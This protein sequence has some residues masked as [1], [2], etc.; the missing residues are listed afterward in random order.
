MTRR[1]FHVFASL[2]EARAYRHEHGC[3][4]WI[5]QDDATGEATI[6]PPDMT[7]TAILQ[8]PLARG[9][10]GNLIGNG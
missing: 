8:H 3:G 1:S 6:F 9:R 4:G 7:P 5:F 2:V 10:T